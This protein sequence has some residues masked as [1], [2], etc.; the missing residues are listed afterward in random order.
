[1]AG[2]EFV[3]PNEPAD[4]IGTRPACGEI[5]AKVQKMCFEKRLVVEKG[6]RNGSVMRCLC[7]L[8]ISD[9]DLKKALDI[10][11]EVVLAVNAEYTKKG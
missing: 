8:N 1:M 3:N 5:A 2:T 7:A 9:D 6:G 4:A 10:F 11:E